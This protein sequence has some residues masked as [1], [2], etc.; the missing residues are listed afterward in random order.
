MFFPNKTRQREVIQQDA[1][2]KG[3]EWDTDTEVICIAELRDQTKTLI[4]Q[5]ST[6]YKA[7]FCIQ[8]D[9]LR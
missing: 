3:V 2:D 6:F 8:T 9:T 5:Y 1:K 4:S 7:D